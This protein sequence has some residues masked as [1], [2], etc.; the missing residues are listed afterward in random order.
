MFG[1]IL[2]IINMWEALNSN[3][4]GFLTYKNTSTDFNS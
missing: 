3:I 4:Q 1:I 2:N